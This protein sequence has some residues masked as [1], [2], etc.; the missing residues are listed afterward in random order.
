MANGVSVDDPYN[1]V[2]GLRIGE[3]TVH[4]TKLP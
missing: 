2:T 3:T 1:A 4:V